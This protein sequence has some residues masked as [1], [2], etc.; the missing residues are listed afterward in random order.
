MLLL[1]DQFHL[2]I[3]DL[4]QRQV[5]KP[6]LKVSLILEKEMAMINDHIDNA[7]TQEDFLKIDLRWFEATKK[8]CDAVAIARG[9]ERL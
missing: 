3:F 5:P 9:V 8:I 7:E 4:A 1:E 2:L 6:E